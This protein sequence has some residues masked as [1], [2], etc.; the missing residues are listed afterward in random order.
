MVTTRRS[1]F[2]LHLR[3]AVFR[4]DDYTCAH[5]TRQ[6]SVVWLEVDHVVPYSWTAD[7]SFENLQ[8]LCRPCN[9]RKGNR[10]AG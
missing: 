7:D 2:D 4:R 8:T 9:R 1:T 5:C 6:C 3:L 10:Y